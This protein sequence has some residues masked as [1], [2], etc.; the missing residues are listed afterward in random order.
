MIIENCLPSGQFRGSVPLISF[1]YYLLIGDIM[2]RFFRALRKHLFTVIVLAVTMAI[3]LFSLFKEESISQLGHILST[4]DPFWILLAFGTLVVT[5]VL[6]GLC[7]WLLCRHLYPSWTYGRSFMIGI[8]GIFYSAI[9]PFSSGGQPMQIYYMS[10]MG[11]KPGKSAAIISS[12]TITHQTTALT[13]SL[14]LVATKLSFFVENVTHLTMFTIFGL[15]TNII[16]IAAVVLVS[17]NAGFIY[18]LLHTCLKGLNKIHIVKNPEELYQT[19]IKQLDSFHAGFK[20]MGKNCGRLYVLVCSITI[21]QLIFGS[22]DTYC[23]YRAFHLHGASVWLIIA[24]EVFAATVVAFVPL[25]G[26]SGGAEI[27]FKAFCTIFFGSLTTPAILVWR[28][29]T[30]YGTILFGYILV[31]L[32]SR[33]YVGTRPPDEQL[34]E[35]KA[36]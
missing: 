29:I 11:M 33:R 21:V 6:E 18:R 8:T 19:I 1:P 35:K 12:K 16:F 7:N 3:L 28:L 25:P 26:G 30:Y 14:L 22:L 24:A 4:L 20:T 17:V 34:I 10:K 15:V 27:S 31:L 2:K 5:W 23:I 13:F 9:T 32:G 36:A